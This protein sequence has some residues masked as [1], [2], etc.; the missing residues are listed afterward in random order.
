VSALFVRLAR[1][2][3]L[4]RCLAA[5]H[6]ALL[7]AGDGNCLPCVS[8]GQAT[9]PSDQITSPVEL[10]QLAVQPHQV[11]PEHMSSRVSEELLLVC[12]YHCLHHKRIFLS[13]CMPLKKFVSI[14][15]R[16]VW[17][18][19]LVLG[20]EQKMLESVNCV[21]EPQTLGSHMHLLSCLSCCSCLLGSNSCKARCCSP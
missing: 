11:V 15:E 13:A 19:A 7:A 16:F 21:K 1:T 17:E 8:G 9:V 6:A 12:L 10:Q 18:I 14:R 3:Q 2:D 4:G 20:P 5:G